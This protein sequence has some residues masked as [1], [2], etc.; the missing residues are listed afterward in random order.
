MSASLAHAPTAP[1]GPVMLAAVREVVDRD[2]APIAAT[3][4]REGTYPE[5]VMRGLGRAGAYRQHLPGFDTEVPDIAAAIRSV[6]AA[7][8]HCLSTSFCM[9]CQDALAWYVWT[10]DN[11]ALKARVGGAIARGEI[12][13]G[14]GLSNPMKTFFGI[15][16]MR[17]KGRRTEGGWLVKGALPWV[18]NLGPDHWF[19]AVFAREDGRPVMALVSCAGPGVK[20]VDGGQ[21]MALDGT[22]TYGIQL[23]D[24]FI[25]DG[26]VLADPAEPYV[27]RIRGGFVLMQVG[28]GLG[29]ARGCIRLIREVEGSLGH[30]NKYLDVGADDLAEQ[31]DALEAQA[32]ALAEGAYDAE[33]VT[34]RAIVQ[35]R[36]DASELAVSAAHNAM[37]H[38]GAR[39]YVVTGEA[40]RRLREAYFVAIVTPAVKQL[41]KMLAD[42]DGASAA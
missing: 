6:A 42:I 14:T 3:I 2:L 39:G 19:G 33:P 16:Q 18:S 9:W 40:Q 7:G 5:A 17:L 26:D 12:L 15:E 25:P 31:A 11:V 36:L 8:E 10:S 20:L 4:D 30:V 38:C 41:K 32:V 27:K 34:W 35:A 28:M 24:A 22:R 21:F 23:R 29:L 13:G 37:L 1:S